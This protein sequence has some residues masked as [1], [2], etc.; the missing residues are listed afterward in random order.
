MP[1]D[2]TVFGSFNTVEK[3][4]VSSEMQGNTLTVILCKIKKQVLYK[5]YK[6]HRGYIPI[7]K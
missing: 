1:K 7:P 6:W 3:S 4:K 5:Q 2:S